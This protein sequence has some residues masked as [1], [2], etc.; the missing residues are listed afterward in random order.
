MK[1]TFF[2]YLSL[3][4]TGGMVYYFLE[5]FTRNY[6]HVSMIICGGLCMVACG[7]LNQIFPNMSILL[8]M[9]LSGIIIT[10][11]ELATG[12]VVNTI[13]KIGVWDYSYMPYN[14]MGQICLA[15]SVL[16]IF[17]SLII[18]FV[19]DGI[20]HFLFDEELPD[21]SFFGKKFK[22]RILAKKKSL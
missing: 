3:F 10:V 22:R 7:S 19:D 16:W 15:Y 5:I 13:L 17:L 8:Q 6:S 14:F 18:I 12:L 21:Y 4:L 11:L 1:I 2:K 9:V 20:R